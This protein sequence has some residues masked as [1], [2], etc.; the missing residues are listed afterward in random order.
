M[1]L[2]LCSCTGRTGEVPLYCDMPVPDFMVNWFHKRADAQIMGLEL[3]S[4]ALGDTSCIRHHL[5]G[6]VPVFAGI[7][8][9]APLIEHRN[10]VIWSDN[11]GAECSYRKGVVASFHY[12]GLSCHCVCVTGTSKK[13]DHSCLIH[14]M[15]KRLLELDV[16]VWIERVPT[17]DNIAD[18]P[19]RRVACFSRGRRFCLLRIV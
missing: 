3:L 2:H 11:V 13:F 10:M 4:I 7:S 6:V 8:S 15:W 18:D 19:S 9:F 17:D 12:T 5:S 16:N 14:C 1:R